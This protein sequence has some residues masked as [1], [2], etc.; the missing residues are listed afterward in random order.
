M[1]FLWIKHPRSGEPDAM[2]TLAVAATVIALF[3]FAMNGVS[4]TIST[5]VLQF[6]SVDAGLVG[7]ILAPTLSAYVA[8]KFKDSPDGKKEVSD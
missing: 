5:S 8:R 2:L 3:K 7:S 6:G 1:N 4:I